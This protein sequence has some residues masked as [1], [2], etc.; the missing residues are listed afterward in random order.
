MPLLR[1][2]D[3]Q[4]PQLPQVGQPLPDGLGVQAAAVGDDALAPLEDVIDARLVPLDFLLE[5]LRSGNS[6]L[7]MPGREGPGAGA[8]LQ[9]SP[10][11]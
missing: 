5:G 11:P 7:S 10:P 4:A 1:L 8:S 3:E 9:S 6:M 2:L